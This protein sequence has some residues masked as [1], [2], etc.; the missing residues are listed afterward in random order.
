MAFFVDLSDS[1]SISNS[2]NRLC[3]KV[4]DIIG[5]LNMSDR[6][7]RLRVTSLSDL[8]LEQ[9]KSYSNVGRAA[10]RDVCFGTAAHVPMTGMHSAGSIGGPRFAG[11]AKPKVLWLMSIYQS[12]NS[13]A[14]PDGTEI[15]PIVSE[16][17]RRATH[18]LRLMHDW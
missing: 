5:I 1:K 10:M 3:A 15:S 7:G 13:A 18:L 2:Q 8:V 17:K 14:L 9:R 4:C 12:I 6:A 11:R 16:A